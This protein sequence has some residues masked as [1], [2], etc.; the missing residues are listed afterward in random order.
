MLASTCSYICVKHLYI[1]FTICTYIKWLYH[2]H[3]S[4]SFYKRKI[5]W[6]KLLIKQEQKPVI[7]KNKTFSFA[8]HF[9]LVF[10]V[11]FFVLAQNC[12]FLEYNH[13]VRQVKG[14]G[15]RGGGNDAVRPLW[16]TGRPRE[17]RVCEVCFVPLGDVLAVG[18]R[19]CR[20]RHSRAPTLRSFSDAR[21]GLLRAGQAGGLRIGPSTRPLLGT[22][23]SSNPRLALRAKAGSSTVTQIANGAFP[24]LLTAT[25]PQRRDE[26]EWGAVAPRS[27]LPARRSQ[28][29]PALGAGAPCGESSSAQHAL[30]GRRL[31]PF[32]NSAGWEAGSGP[33]S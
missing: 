29:A 33:G 14:G 30:P 19:V 10:G 31:R 11:T 13:S 6:G 18:P 15:G 7:L 28:A 24:A 2:K 16:R 17:A 1:F 4:M 20:V 9:Y 22:G 21:L 12:H 26:S 5:K 32:R 25:R 23:G 27:R 3:C 8:F